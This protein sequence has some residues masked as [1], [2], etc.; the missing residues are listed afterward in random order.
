M[1]S[2]ITQID[3]NCFEIESDKIDPFIVY[4]GKLDIRGK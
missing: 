1:E 2:K 4:K 3:K